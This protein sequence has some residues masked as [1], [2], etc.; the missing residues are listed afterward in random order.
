MSYGYD[1]MEQWL[2]ASSYVD[3]ILRGAKAG[4]LP[5]Q[6]ATKYQMVI[7]LKAANALGLK[8]PDK[9]LITAD[10]VIE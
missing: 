3:R 6:L 10:E 9:F 1:P 7:N 8:M 2:G 5:V 4:E